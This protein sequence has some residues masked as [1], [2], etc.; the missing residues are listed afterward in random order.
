MA[1]D[2]DKWR[3]RRHWDPRVI[4]NRMDAWSLG[5]AN[6]GQI[7]SAWWLVSD[8]AQTE[9][10]WKWLDGGLLLSPAPVPVFLQAQFIYGSQAGPLTRLAWFG[11]NGFTDEQVESGVSFSV[12][13]QVVAYMFDAIGGESV[14][15]IS[16]LKTMAPA[17]NRAF[18]FQPMTKT[19]GLPIV[20]NPP[21][22]TWE[23][24]PLD[25]CHDCQT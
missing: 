18:S 6:R 25:G 5:F 17:T 20:T 13:M 12:E 23:L 11:F 14:T 16:P 1:C 4:D 15:A 19:G 2:T 7:A 21:L 8:T 22:G 10:P 24:T 9:N 3:K